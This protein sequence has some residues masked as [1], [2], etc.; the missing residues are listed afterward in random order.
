MP[1]AGDV[2][3]S[4]LRDDNDREI[5]LDCATKSVGVGAA[6]RGRTPYWTVDTGRS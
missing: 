6:M 1:D 3:K 5:L 2:V 4:W